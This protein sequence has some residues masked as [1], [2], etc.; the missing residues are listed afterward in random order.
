M[1]ADGSPADLAATGLHFGEAVRFRRFAN[2][3]WR[4]GRAVGIE[5]DG[6]L[7]IT[8]DNGAARAIPVALVEARVAGP[9]GAKRWEPL[10]RRAKRADQL[11][12]FS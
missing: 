3:P 10:Q 11:T 5:R 9:R 12:L 2:G 7:A 4:A 6:S 1:T 8:D